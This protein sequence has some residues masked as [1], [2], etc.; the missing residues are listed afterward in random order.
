MIMK[1][2]NTEKKRIMIVEDSIIVVQ[3]LTMI[4]ENAGYEIS[5]KYSSGEEVIEN[6]QKDTPD[7]ILMDIK[8]DGEMTGIETAAEIK[9]IKEIPV[10]YTTAYS[11][12]ETLRDMNLT[13]PS[14]YLKKPYDYRELLITIGLALNRFEFNKKIT[15]SEHKYRNLFEN[16]GNAIFILDTSGR[17]SDCNDSFLSLFG[18][19]REE[20]GAL[21]IGDLM[22]IR[23]DHKF[24]KDS[25]NDLGSIQ[26]HD[27]AMKRKGGGVLN[28]QLTSSAILD[29]EGKTCGYHG[30]IRDITNLKKSIEEQNI[31]LDAIVEAM[32][33]TV[34]VRDPYTAGHQRRV[35]ELSYLIARLMGIPDKKMKEIKM[36]A[37]IHDLG[38]IYVPSEILSKPGK[39]LDVEF[40]LIKRHSTVGYDILK[41]VEFHFPLA[42]IIHQHHERIDGSGYPQGLKGN[43]I[44]MEA[45]II[46][47]S[48]VVEA[49]ASH[50]PYRPAL[51]IDA[52][53]K[54]I[55]KN[56]GKLYDDSV[57]TAFD[58]LYREHSLDELF[59]N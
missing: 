32:A 30:I 43:D 45:K 15:A 19:L 20:T 29:D 52:S 28:C 17:I 41:G 5:G 40:D 7:L 4:L 10:I 6:F 11:D 24:I 39:I 54:E 44:L 9:K 50:R 12:D 37:M 55:T 53:Y 31:L 13:D 58:A 16:S 47:V 36:A 33:R 51:G 14:A 1:K 46:T 22:L 57:V 3:E 25:V 35:A 59:H 56:S 34:E 8:L 27:I 49:M 23:E 2:L 48:D 38:K 42:N 26:N 18:Y 21:H